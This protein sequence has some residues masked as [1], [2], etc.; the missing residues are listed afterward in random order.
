M[1]N[2][3]S[4]VNCLESSLQKRFDKTITCLDR[5]KHYA[6]RN[7]LNAAGR[8]QRDPFLKALEFDLEVLRRRIEVTRQARTEEGY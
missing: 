1:R 6:R 3:V 4:I 8:T 2:D 5:N 7:P